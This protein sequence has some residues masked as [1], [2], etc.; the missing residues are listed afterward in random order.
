MTTAPH[1]TKPRY[2]APCNGCGLCCRLE[3]CRAGV[4]ALRQLGAE[5][6]APC[7][8][9]VEMDGR[10]WCKLVLVEAKHINQLPDKKPRIAE[11]LAIGKGCTMDDD[12]EGVAA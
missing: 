1:I 9:L 8:L 5:P 6:V 12:E 3:V 11:G 7:I 2:G 4:I 10:Y